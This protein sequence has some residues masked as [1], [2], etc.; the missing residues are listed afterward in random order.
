MMKT[1][2]RSSQDGLP[3]MGRQ[4]APRKPTRP[5]RSRKHGQEEGVVV[6]TDGGCDPNP[7]VGG[8]AAVLLYKG[9]YKELSGGAPKTTNNRMEMTAAIEAL[10]A[11][12][13]PCVVVVHTDS[14]YLKRGITEWL[15]AW[16][17]R[18]WARKEGNLKNADLWKQLDTLIH[19]HRVKWKWVPGHSG[20]PLNE[21]CDALVREEILKR[22]RV[23]QGGRH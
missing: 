9:K 21:R 7:G 2:D 19:T 14:E 23:Q 13:R 10:Q 22:T 4:L 18:N 8:W 3:A 20:N 16:K 11:L 6:Y 15:P 17:C 1:R 5:A 12:N